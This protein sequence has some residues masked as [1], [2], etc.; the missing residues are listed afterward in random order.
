MGYRG[1][2]PVGFPGRLRDMVEIDAT[3]WATGD[4]ARYNRKEYALYKR[5]PG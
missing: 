3:G 1:F 2:L 4:K 5:Y